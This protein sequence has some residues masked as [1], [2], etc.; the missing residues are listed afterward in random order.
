MS[1]QHQPWQCYWVGVEFNISL[2]HSALVNTIQNTNDH[3]NVKNCNTSICKGI[4]C[5]TLLLLP[6]LEGLVPNPPSPCTRVSRE[7]DGHEMVHS[8]IECDDLVDTDDDLVGEVGGSVSP[9][10]HLDNI[11]L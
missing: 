6:W 8:F 11:V 5:C 1:K 9:E 2:G 4:I 3:I 7:S 10:I